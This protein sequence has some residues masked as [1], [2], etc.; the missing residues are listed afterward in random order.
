MEKIDQPKL[1]LSDRI[2]ANSEAAPWVVDAVVEIENKISDLEKSLSLEKK[3]NM[4]IRQLTC[5]IEDSRTS[6]E[7]LEQCEDALE[8]L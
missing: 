7:R 8:G 6:L 5:V 3:R 2:R 4:V 1:A